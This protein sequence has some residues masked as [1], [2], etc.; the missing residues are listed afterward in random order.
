MP[1]KAALIYG[2]AA[3]LLNKTIKAALTR[4]YM[5]DEHVRGCVGLYAR[6]KATSNMF[7]E[8]VGAFKHAENFG[9]F[10]AHIYT[11]VE[12]TAN[13]FISVHDGSRKVFAYP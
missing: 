9:V 3:Q 1:A 5:F 4:A 7:I 8:H 2:S 11:R 10:D 6:A 13:M 12:D